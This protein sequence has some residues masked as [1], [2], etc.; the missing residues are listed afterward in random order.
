M[1]ILHTILNMLTM[2]SFTTMMSGPPKPRKQFMSINTIGFYSNEYGFHQVTIHLI[3]T[4]HHSIPLLYRSKIYDS[5]NLVYT[6]LKHYPVCMLQAKP[7]ICL[8]IL[9][10]DFWLRFSIKDVHWILLF[11]TVMPAWGVVFNLDL[12]SE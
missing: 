3:W 1:Q 12:L 5:H 4:L 10:V 2:D 6:F 8:N 11:G 9:L 7:Q